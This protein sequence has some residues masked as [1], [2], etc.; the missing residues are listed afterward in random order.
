MHGESTRPVYVAVMLTLHTRL[1]CQSW[2]QSTVQHTHT[3]SQEDLCA[4]SAACHQT[5]LQLVSPWLYE[6]NFFILDACV[7]DYL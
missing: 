3:A 5:P 4:C 1:Q 7:D 6:C 2:H